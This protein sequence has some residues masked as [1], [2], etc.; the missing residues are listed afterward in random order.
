MLLWATLSKH[1]KGHMARPWQYQ[2]RHP[3]RMDGPNRNWIQTCVEIMV[4]VKSDH[5]KPK[6]TPNFYRILA[7]AQTHRR[8][9]DTLVHDQSARRQIHNVPNFGTARLQRWERSLFWNF[10]K[11]HQVVCAISNCWLLI[12]LESKCYQVQVTKP[13]K[14]ARRSSYI[15]SPSVPTPRL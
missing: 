1:T 5:Y 6:S 11:S 9:V 3:P 14:T 15:G 8:L 10:F 2:K 4:C 7:K 13:K 12:Q